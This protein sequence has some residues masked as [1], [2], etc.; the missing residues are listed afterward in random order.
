MNLSSETTTTEIT[1]TTGDHLLILNGQERREYFSA[2][3][4]TYKRQNFFE[5]AFS[6][7]YK[8]LSK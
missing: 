8:K 6:K 7:V 5:Q 3:T 2:I 1:A 4:S